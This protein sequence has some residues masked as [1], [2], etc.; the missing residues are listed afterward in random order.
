MF[1]QTFYEIASILILAAVIGSLAKLLRQPLIIAFLATGI[2]AG[3]S[4]FSI[5]QSHSQIETLAQ[6]GIAL[7]LFVV[8]LKLDLNLIKTTGRSLLPRVWGKY[9][10]HQYSVSSL[11]FLWVFLSSPPHNLG[12]AHLFQHHHYRQ[13]SL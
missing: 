4:G 13:T 8:G 9:Y 6:I 10:L 7:L 12:G 11:S 2:L 1:E 5:L 3:P